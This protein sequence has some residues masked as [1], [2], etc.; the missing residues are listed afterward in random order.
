MFLFF[1]I[2]YLINLTSGIDLKEYSDLEIEK[3]YSNRTVSQISTVLL[4]LAFVLCAFQETRIVTVVIMLFVMAFVATAKSS[5]QDKE[6][7]NLTQI[8]SLNFGNQNSLLISDFEKVERIEPDAAQQ[9]WLR[10]IME[11]LKHSRN[12]I[13]WY[14][15]LDLLKL[16][17]EKL[18]SGV[19]LTMIENIQM[20]MERSSFD[21]MISYLIDGKIEKRNSKIQRLRMLL[22]FNVITEPVDCEFTLLETVVA[23]ISIIILNLGLF[24]IRF[25]RKLGINGRIIVALVSI[26]T[27]VLVVLEPIRF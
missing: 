8:L 11:R 4:I 10:R 19:A 1:I 18:K 14:N 17:L 22:V 2:L 15:N 23:A 6:E 3:N 21:R 16:E 25:R 12:T 27:I 20:N 26:G 24:S 13:E 7:L 5:N 9:A